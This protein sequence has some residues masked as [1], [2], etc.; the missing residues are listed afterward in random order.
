MVREG[1]YVD[2]LNANPS[3]RWAA[4]PV[5]RWLAILVAIASFAGAG[6]ALAEWK[7]A[8]SPRFIVYSDGSERDLR[9]YVR[10]LE[11]FDAFLRGMFGVSPEAPGRKLPVFLLDGPQAMSRIH[12]GM[13]SNVAGYYRP[14][15]EDIYAVSLRHQGDDI[16]LHE[17]FH[18]FSYQT[19]AAVGYPAWLIEG[20]A[21]YFMTAEIEGDLVKVGSYNRGRVS[22]LANQTWIPIDLLVTNHQ[23]DVRNGQQQATYYPLAWLLTHWFQSD[24]ARRAQLD[25]YIAAV[26]TGTPSYQALQ[27]VTGL[28]AEGL[29]RELRS[30][31]NTS[32]KVVGGE[33]SSAAG[34]IVVTRLP[35]SA[36]DL[37]L[38]GQRLK[39]D[40]ASEHRAATLEAIQ[41]AAARYPDDLF[42]LRVLAHAEFK[43]GD[44]ALAEATL[45]RILERDPE[46]IDALLLMARRRMAEAK[47][48]PE[49]KIDLMGRARAYLARAHAADPTHYYTLYLLA[50]SRV[51][52]PG[53]PNENDIAT[54]V[55]AFNQAP[56]MPAIRLGLAEAVMRRGEFELAGTLLEPLANAAHRGSAVAYAQR[57]LVSA[58]AGQ[59][60]EDAPSTTGAA[61]PVPDATPQQPAA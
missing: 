2:V 17:Y 31:L 5:A 36:D 11:T 6:P 44:P 24:S 30:Y 47:D 60:P 41:G 57:L 54:W 28:S 18:H 1:F 7:R 25:A 23:N 49:Q 51:A 10:K 38:L 53:Y 45:T 48:A 26:R 37:L 32:L 22:Q 34:D 39:G 4:H 40:L 35:R 58:R 12:P 33:V 16:L 14:S 55:E 27:T 56:Q 50:Q 19:Q 20:L 3:R 21:E 59:L 15:G 61:S 13:R 8:E 9:D 52:A 42:A 46:N 43:L 29:R